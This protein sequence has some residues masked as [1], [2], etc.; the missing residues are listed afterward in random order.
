[1]SDLTKLSRED[2]NLVAAAMGVQGAAEMGNKDD[3]AAAVLAT[4]APPEPPEP[5]YD[6]LPLERRESTGEWKC[7]FCESPAGN[8]E[9]KLTTCPTPMCGAVVDGDEV[10]RRVDG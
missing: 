5:E 2:L 10:V 8:N 6:R 3:V 9:S 1:M 7:P 4:K